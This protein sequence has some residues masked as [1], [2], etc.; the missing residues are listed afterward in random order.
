LVTVVHHLDIDWFRQRDGRDQRAPPRSLTLR[1]QELFQAIFRDRL[2]HLQAY[3]LLRAK[4]DLSYH[5]FVEELRATHR[6]FND[7]P[8]LR[9][10]AVPLL[11]PVVASTADAAADTEA[12]DVQRRLGTVLAGLATEEQL[13]LRFFIVNGMPAAEVARLVGWPD[14]KAVYNRVYRLLKSLRRQLLGR[15][16]G[17]GD[18]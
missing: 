9:S 6:A 1:Q 7:A 11:S 13:A 3:E 4:A 15:G 8:R 16:I 14:A 12:D 5:E 18:W 2:P 10:R 17:P